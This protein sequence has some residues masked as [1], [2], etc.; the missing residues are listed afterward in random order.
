MALPILRETRAG[1]KPTIN[2]QPKKQLHTCPT[3]AAHLQQYR[4][5]LYTGFKMNYTELLF[6]IGFSSVEKHVH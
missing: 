4:L 5:T 2:S 6:Y 3:A 1:T